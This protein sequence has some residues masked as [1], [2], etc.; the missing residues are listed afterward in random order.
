MKG[1]IVE[2]KIKR[3]E[4]IQADYVTL[5]EKHLNDL[6]EGKTDEMFEIED[7]ADILCTLLA[8]MKK[9]V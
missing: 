7:F 1:L 9:K 2:T 5:I 6:L 8:A 3:P 4:Q